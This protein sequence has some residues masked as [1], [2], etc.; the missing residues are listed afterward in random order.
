M[1]R[2]DDFFIDITD[3]PAPQPDPS[4]WPPVVIPKEAIDAEVRRLAELPAP[5]N[6]RRESLIVHPSAEAPGIGLAP[7]IRVT[8]CVLKPGERTTPVRQNATQVN[9]CIQGGGHTVVDGKRIDFT[10]FDTW[11]LPG[12]STY[13]HVNDTDEL[14][15]RLNY[16]NAA[17]L[18]KMNIFYMEEDAE[19]PPP[20]SVAD[21]SGTTSVDVPE[22]GFLLND[23]GA[24]LM[25]YEDLINPPP[26]ASRA[27]HWPWDEVKAE[28]DKL[29]SLGE[30]YVGRRLYLMYNPI[31]GRT[32]GTTPSFF[33]T[34]TIR[35]AGI[36]DRPHRHS[37]AAINYYFAGR[38]YSVVEGKRLEWKAGDL[39]L[40]AP[41]WAVHNHASHDEAVYEL[42]IQDQPLN[43]AMESLLWQEDLKGPVRLLGKDAGFQT[44]RSKL[45]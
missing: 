3:A 7:G 31:T 1:A 43:I 35:P 30:K 45:G 41:G 13:Q 6:G 23:S 14:Q 33:A 44:N 25:S 24:H 36:I 27:L 20:Q 29:A 16:S 26:V 40:S 39:M 10:R 5:A 19:L 4:R 28:L 38:G 9:F 12:L 18:E 21:D 34:I 22:R 11:N 8:L 17:L 32:N 2:S 42:T 15:V 37:S